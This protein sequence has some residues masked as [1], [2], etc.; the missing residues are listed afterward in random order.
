M[1]PGHALT[2]LLFA[3]YLGPTAA[4]DGCQ[5]SGRS[6]TGCSPTAA[7]SSSPGEQTAASSAYLWTANDADYG[8][9]TVS[10]IAEQP[11][12]SGAKYREVAR[13]ASVTCQSDP[14]N[15]SKEGAIFSA[16]PPATLCADGTHGC[17]SRAET[18]AGANG[19]HQP[20]NLIQNRPIRTAIDMNGDMWVVNAANGDTSR[21][22]SITL[23]AG[24][25]ERCVERNGIAGIQTSSD[26][27][28]DGIIE[29]DCNNNGVADDLSDVNA[30]AACLPGH[31]QEFYGLDDECI[32]FTANIG[33]VG[34]VARA[35]ALGKG[36]TNSAPPDA[37]VGT[38]ANGTFYRIDATTGAIKNSVTLVPHAGL[39]SHP[40][41]AVIDEFGILWAENVASDGGCT[42][43]CVFYFDTGAVA[44]QD[45]I[46]LPGGL[47]ISGFNGI[48]LDGYRGAG[49]LVQQI[50]FGAYGDYGAYRYRPVRSAGFA[51]IRNGTWA[52][53]Q[54]KG[55]GQIASARGVALDNRNPAYAWVALDGGGVGRIAA[56]MPDGANVFSTA[57]NLFPTNQPL[58]VG[59]GVAA[60]GDVWAVNLGSSTLTHFSVDASGNVTNA[61]SPDQLSLDDRP[62]APEASCAHPQFLQCKPHP[63]SNSDF[64]GYAFL[65]FTYPGIDRIFANGFD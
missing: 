38:Y 62:G 21:Q 47:A 54:V 27:N 39:A 56:D 2:A 57:G 34:D 23:I 43:G 9:G 55:T 63:D 64:T 8:T 48:A 26:A 52:L 10:K 15:G 44:S 65:T 20:V 46:A 58:T 7:L 36:A 49:G 60:S 30:G 31:V 59:T 1:N 24:S 12:A 51:A 14:L 18:I 5:G 42:T 29:T 33:A 13:Y 3:C 37:W 28:G 16:T 4:S 17:C 40:Y 61:G 22:S 19:M 53:G 32:V 50:W 45:A 6:D 11:F 41:G 35:L 25:L